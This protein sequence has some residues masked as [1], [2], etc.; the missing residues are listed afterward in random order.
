MSTERRGRLAGGPAGLL[1]LPLMAL[2]CDSGTTAPPP[3]P[4]PAGPVTASEW[5]QSVDWTRASVVQVNMVEQ[6]DAYA[7]DPAALSFEAGKPYILRIVNPASNAEKHYFATEG[8]GD[9]YQ[10]IA[11]R[12][13]QT[14]DAEYKAPHFEAVE[15][16]IGGSLEIYF[17]PVLA[18]TY[19]ILCTIPG[20]KQLGMFGK[21][22]ITG[23]TGNRLDL[24]IATDFDGSLAADG[25]KSSS[26][27]VW[28]ARSDATMQFVEEPAYGFDPTDVSLTKGIGYKLTLDNTAAANGSKHYYTA[29]E[30]YR[31][32]VLRKAQDTQAEIKALYFSAI[33][34]LVGRKTDLYIVPTVAGT[35]DTE[36][37]IPGHADA[38]MR[39]TVVVSE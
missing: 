34:L 14:A 2:A 15:L 1:L 4:P 6:G 38:G 13:I 24:E 10:A 39:G 19:D 32:V 22:T 8:L 12:K 21:A 5:I 33:E 20:H 31:T 36:C 7:F 11:T 9:F 17:V 27:A 18:G 3:P 29:P 16:L 30:F 28:N 25:R 23:G 37:T 26:H 35:F